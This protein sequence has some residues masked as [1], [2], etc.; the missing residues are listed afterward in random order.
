[1]NTKLHCNTYE[2][3]AVTEVTT[4]FS[5]FQQISFEALWEGQETILD[6]QLKKF[7]GGHL[8]GSVG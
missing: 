4:G 2:S 5:Q 7:L 1:M 8:G 3:K 6:S